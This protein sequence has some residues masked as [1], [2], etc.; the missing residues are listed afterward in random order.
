MQELITNKPHDKILG[1]LINE[2]DKCSS[3]KIAIAFITFSGVNLLLEVLNRLEQK[4]VKGEI[5]TGDYL[6]FTEPN[7]LSKINEF[8]NIS[9]R[10]LRGEQF[11]AKGFLF[12]S[13]VLNEEG[14]ASNK[15]KHTM[16]IG[17]SNL[18]QSALTTSIEWNTLCNVS[19]IKVTQFHENFNILWNKAVDI[20]KCIDDYTIQYQQN[21]MKNTQSIIKSASNDNDSIVANDMQVEALSKLSELRSSG[22]NKGLVL[23]ATGSGKTILSALDVKQFNSHKLLFIVH[24]SN[25]AIEAQATFERVVRNKSCGLFNGETKELNK[26]CI[27]ATIQ[28]LVNNLNQFNPNDFDYII[29]DEVHHG[30]AK[31]YLQVINYFNPKFM[32]GLTAT[33]ERSDGFNIFELFDYNIAY[34][35]NLR[36]AMNDQ[37]LS[38]FHYFGVTDIS[39]DDELITDNANINQLTSGSRVTHIIEKANLYGYLKEEVKGLIFVSNVNEAKILCEKLN[40]LNYKCTYLSSEHNTNDRLRTIGK[41]ENGELEYIITV[42]IFNEGIDIPCVNQVLLLRP[43]ESQIVYLQQI[44]R[45]LRKYKGKEFVVILDFIGNYKNNFLIPAAISSNRTMDRDYLRDD[46]IL[47]GTNVIEG[48]SV[49]QFEKQV[50][51]D[52]IDKIT[53]TNF[54]KVA[55]IKKDYNYLKAKYNRI[56]RLVDFTANNLLSPEVIV[57][58]KNYAEM[59]NQLER[60]KIVSLDDNQTLF[61]DYITCNLFP[62]R[63]PHELEAINMLL[64]S[65]SISSEQLDSVVQKKYYTK[66]NSLIT[67]NALNHLAREIFQSLSDEFKYIPFIN[68]VSEGMYKISSEFKEAIA[69]KQF[70]LEL[71]DIIK[72]SLDAYSEENYDVNNKLTIGCQY[73]RKDAYKCSLFD[74]NN[75]YQVSGQTVFGNEMIIFITLDDTNSFTKFDNKMLDN[76]SFTWFSKANRKLE[77]NK[78]ILTNEGKL[79]NNELTQLVFMKRTSSDYFKYMG[80]T[81]RC[82]EYEIQEINGKQVIKYIMEL[83]G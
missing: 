81:K 25:I 30:G 23:S 8:S 68:K 39:I 47:N 61:L 10:L 36:L 35:Y 69:S 33:P 53:N 74:F 48:A 13:N 32:L 63:R 3:F 73:S 22:E 17:S 14:I 59:K 21:L 78:G 65:N 12:E 28:T 76:N 62:C 20:S 6:S 57:K 54:S 45:G 43:T 29:I 24:R 15:A 56:P 1:R 49:I 38:P 60:D 37:I 41:L 80:R 19:D 40:V 51:D 52:L 77:G 64:S 83:D 27:F 82:K 44:G 67:S 18:T 31:S 50:S 26:D 11:H 34:E 42:D 72:V 4:G 7:A 55:M 71:E 16:I 5:I 79:A 75:G 58:K 9:L 70:V 2:F 46:V 66:P